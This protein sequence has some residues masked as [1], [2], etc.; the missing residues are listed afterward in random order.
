MKDIVKIFSCTTIKIVNLKR[1]R[2]VVHF[3]Y[4]LGAP[5]PNAG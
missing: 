1:C 5:S 3:D 2:N 4:G